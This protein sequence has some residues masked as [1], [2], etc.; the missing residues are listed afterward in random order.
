MMIYAVVSYPA[1][2]VGGKVRLYV[3][4]SRERA[5]IIYETLAEHYFKSVE[6]LQSSGT[7]NL[8]MGLT[9]FGTMEGA[10]Q[11]TLEK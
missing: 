7:L 6:I 1:C 11:P 4:I 10:S 3:G 2:L 8:C 5:D 9:C